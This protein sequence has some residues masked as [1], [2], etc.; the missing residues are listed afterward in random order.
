MRKSTRIVKRVF[1]LLLVVLMS[2][3]TLGAV[4]SDNDGSAFITKAEFDSLKNDFQSQID[5]Y[6]TS[7]DSKIDGAIASYLAGIDIKK[8]EVL[9]PIISN[10]ADI[11]WKNDL[12]YYLDV[13]TYT[14]T[15]TYSHTGAKWQTPKFSE[16]RNLRCGRYYYT[17]TTFIDVN[18][19]EFR[20]NFYADS[21]WLNNNGWKSDG[22]A[23]SY[24]A[25]NYRTSPAI[26]HC[27]DRYNNH[28]ILDTTWTRPLEREQ[29]MLDVGYP[30][31][32]SGTK[33]WNASTVYGH[34]NYKAYKG[35]NGG[36]VID[37]A[38]SDSLLNF[39]V[40]FYEGTD[41]NN[42]SAYNPTKYTT[43]VLNFPKSK[44]QFGKPDFQAFT[45][46]GGGL[47]SD[48]D[49]SLCT[50]M[51]QNV[52]DNDNQ[53][54]RD[55]SLFKYMMLGSDSNLVVNAA[56]ESSTPG[57]TAHPQTFDY[58][59]AP[60]KEITF[61]GSTL[62]ISQNAGGWSNDF[63]CITDSGASATPKFGMP[64][65][66]RYY[67]KDIYNPNFKTTAGVP[68]QIGEGLPIG[69]SFSK[70]GTLE[71]KMKYSVIDSDLNSTGAP[72][73]KIKISCKKSN[74]INAS[75]ANSDYFTEENGTLLQ[76][77]SWT[78]SD[79]TDPDWI[80]KIPVKKGE[81]M[82]LRIGP[83]TA[84]P[85]GYYAKISQMDVKLTAE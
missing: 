11:V 38:T 64:I 68:L 7:I 81:S 76:N 29:R 48:T 9:D 2:I 83:D 45:T 69:T 27:K 85:N 24:T 79:S 54:G 10:Y 65:W 55:N 39:H 75:S 19:W 77:A 49:E 63:R 17:G 23:R 59:D 47:L 66:P 51:Y 60:L 12:Y 58:T 42:R 80:V 8:E 16:H 41:Y 33:A 21:F 84:T 70:N 22:E 40:I 71:I 4:V 74:F 26:V 1:T 20:F 3:N 31:V 72:N 73:Q 32:V 61:G 14:G 34:L 56:L 50:T 15:K 57:P 18:D 44:Q 62:Y 6:N 46:E 13:Y 36:F 35:P 28:P 78:P 82:W 30:G 25:N 5:Q 53:Y 43:E 37:P 52:I 67:L